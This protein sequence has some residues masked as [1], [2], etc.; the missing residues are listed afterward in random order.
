[1]TDETIEELFTEFIQDVAELHQAENDTA[2]FVAS[3]ALSAEEFATLL[4]SAEQYERDHW[5][6]LV[7][8]QE[9]GTMTIHNIYAQYIWDNLEGYKEDEIYKEAMK[10]LEFYRGAFHEKQSG[11][12]KDV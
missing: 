1:M 6:D 7:Q 3:R 9:D 11:R 8:M 10:L 4:D 2:T 12:L 5:D